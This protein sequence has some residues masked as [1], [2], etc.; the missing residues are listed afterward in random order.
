MIL[1]HPELTLVSSPPT[2]GEWLYVVYE[3]FILTFNTK[4]FATT[5]PTLLPY[6]STFDYS[7][8]QVCNYGITHIPLC[9][10]SYSQSSAMTSYFCFWQY[11]EPHYFS[12]E[13]IIFPVDL[14]AS[15]ISQLL[16]ALHNTFIRN[17]FLNHQS[18]QTFQ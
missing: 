18:N 10:I 2:L 5:K 15:L 1:L 6:F 3:A 12:R 13:S 9:F 7:V 4:I 8:A 17:I 11:P 14:P 16:T